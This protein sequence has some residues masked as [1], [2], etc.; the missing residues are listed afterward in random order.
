MMVEM[1]DDYSELGAQ[2][3]DVLVR[4]YSTSCRE[5]PA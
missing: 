1:D 2:Q 5:E 3:A 4:N